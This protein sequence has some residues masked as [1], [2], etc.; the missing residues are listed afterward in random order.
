MCSAHPSD[1]TSEPLL[2][3][4][5]GLRRECV[6]DP[7]GPLPRVLAHV[8]RA[9]VRAGHGSPDDDDLDRLPIREPGEDLDGR[10]RELE[11]L[12]GLHTRT[13]VE[14]SVWANALG[15]VGHVVDSEQVVV[16]ARQRAPLLIPCCKR[17]I[18]VNPT[19]PAI[20]L[21]LE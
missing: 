10:I 8:E 11:R 2:R 7:E 5:L 17:G 21:E 4:P 14:R 16:G 19:S 12:R 13:I 18:P 15:N 1:L 6:V 20:L 9:P 3:H